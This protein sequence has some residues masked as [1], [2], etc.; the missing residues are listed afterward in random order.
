METPMDSLLCYSQARACDRYIPQK[1]TNEIK[2]T[3]KDIDWSTGI[4]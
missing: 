4:L 2:T 1:D 3:L